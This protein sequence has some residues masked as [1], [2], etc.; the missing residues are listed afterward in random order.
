MFGKTILFSG[1]HY[2]FPKMISRIIS[3][4]LLVGGLG[5]L[6]VQDAAAADLYRLEG[7]VGLPH[8][9]RVKQKVQVESYDVVT[10]PMR[11]GAANTG[12]VSS[13]PGRWNPRDTYKYVEM[14]PLA[15][16]QNQD[17]S[18]HCLMEDASKGRFRFKDLTPGSYKLTFAVPDLGFMEMDVKISA[19]S[20]DSGGR[21]SLEFEFEPEGDVIEPIEREGVSDKA[22]KAFEK[23][24]SE[25]SKGNAKKALKE[26]EKAVKEDDQYAEAWEYMGMI[27][28][29]MEEMED[30][31]KY[32]KKSLE[33]D[34]NSYR[35]LADLG[36]ILLVKGDPAGARDMYEKALLIRPDDP[37]PR[38]QLGMALFQLQELT[39]ALDQL[40]KARTIDS[41][42][43]S[44]PQ[45]LSAEIFRLWG[46]GANMKAE[47]EDF[48]KNFP[49]DPKSAPVRQALAGM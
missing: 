3:M 19:D 13:S 24:A 48:L 22:V 35:S 49:D 29:S 46:D 5:I 40:V 7:K 17:D 39:L 6:L 36:T 42:H 16:L 14:R 38:A 28:H 4:S 27:K 33:I 44:Q 8:A 1:K 12:S 10:A 26:F 32:F 25:F 41:G 31:E 30:A 37:Q 45:L 23:G 15:F 9:G 34:P 18:R 43:F 20:A 47:L 2:F 21:V 11:A